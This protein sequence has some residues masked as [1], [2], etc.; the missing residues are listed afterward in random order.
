MSVEREWDG[1]VEIE[2][3]PYSRV[4]FVPVYWAYAYFYE[5]PERKP[6]CCFYEGMKAINLENIP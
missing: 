4:R 1:D 6:L 2:R 3:R 5:N